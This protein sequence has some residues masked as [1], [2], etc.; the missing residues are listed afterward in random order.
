MTIG[1][2]RPSQIHHD[3]SAASVIEAI[4]ARAEDIRRTELAR[5]GRRWETLAPDDRL[6][7]DALTES[8]VDA[9]VRE[10]TATLQP[11]AVDQ[12][13]LESVRYLFGLE[14]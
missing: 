1:L 9:L 5:L 14:T 7:L 10:L 13:H 3:T 8:I 6:R 4:R 12:A 2:R 11:G